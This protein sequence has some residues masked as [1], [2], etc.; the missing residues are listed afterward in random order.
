MSRTAKLYGIM[1][2]DSDTRR[3]KPFS[4]SHMDEDEGKSFLVRYMVSVD[5]SL[6]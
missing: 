4:F 3:G 6:E 5:F 1:G 2:E